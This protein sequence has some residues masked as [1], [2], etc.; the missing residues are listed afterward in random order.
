MKHGYV[1]LA[2]VA[3]V[4]VLLVVLAN[5]DVDEVV[6]TAADIAHQKGIVAIRNMGAKGLGVV[7]LV[8]IPAWT[9]VGPYPG[10]MYSTKQYEVHMQSG[11]C[12]DEYAIEFWDVLP[13][14]SLDYK[15]IVDP[16][17]EKVL[18]PRYACVAPYVNEP[19]TTGPNLVWVWNLPK[20]RTELWTSRAITAG[21]ELTACY[22]LSY[23]RKYTTACTIPGKEPVRYVI[24]TP[25]QRRPRKWHI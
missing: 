16:F 13:D 18:D 24:T 3:A 7:A 19:D 2:V 11:R 17:V 6:P 10:K 4:V 5:K 22:G 20:H 21:T 8:D 15:Y 14:G 12:H 23:S 25:Q 1:A 9:P